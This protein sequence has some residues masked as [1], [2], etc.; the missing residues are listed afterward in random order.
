MYAIRSY[1]VTARGGAAEQQMVLFAQL[2]YHAGLREDEA[3]S[4]QCNEINPH[5]G[6]LYISA[7]QRRK[8]VHAIR[9]VPLAL[10]PDSVQAALRRQIAEQQILHARADAP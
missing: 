7:R 6:L 4:L 5:T 9:K 3:R 1:Y 2:C 10:L 8:S